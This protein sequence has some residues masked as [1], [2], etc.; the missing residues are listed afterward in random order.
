MQFVIEDPDAPCGSAVT[1]VLQVDD[2][3]RDAI[4]KALPHPTTAAIS[5]RDKVLVPAFSADRM[6][7]NAT[8]SVQGAACYK[9]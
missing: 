5:G 8:L 2:T 9:Q 6:G 3:G 4:R 7:H 1:A